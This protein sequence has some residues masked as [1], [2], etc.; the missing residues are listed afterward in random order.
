MEPAQGAEIPIHAAAQRVV[1]D[2]PGRRQVCEIGRGSAAS[3]PPPR[4]AHRAGLTYSCI[5]SSAGVAGYRARRAETGF[6][7]QPK[8]AATAPDTA[9]P[10]GAGRLEA[11]AANPFIRA[12]PPRIPRI[13]DHPVAQINTR[14]ISISTL[15]SVAYNT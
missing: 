1:E 10:R 7:R 6:A 15:L 3:A 11:L 4:P 8:P 13:A 12:P 14:R 5:P 9:A 2:P